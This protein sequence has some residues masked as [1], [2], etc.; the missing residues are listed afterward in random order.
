MADTCKSCNAP[1]VWAITP[2]G[3]RAP[4]DAE[5]SDKGNIRIQTDAAAPI[6]HYLSEIELAA[7]RASGERLHLSHFVTC[8]QAAQHRRPR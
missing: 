1:I 2:K 5:P 4:I 7:A 8:P 3:K 6:A